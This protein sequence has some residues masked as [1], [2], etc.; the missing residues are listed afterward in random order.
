MPPHI[1]GYFLFQFI[2]KS[3]DIKYVDAAITDM[4]FIGWSGDDGTAGIV[5]D[6]ARASLFR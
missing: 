6:T 5:P 1:T 2:Y 4:S 3:E